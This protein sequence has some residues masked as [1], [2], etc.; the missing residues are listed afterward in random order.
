MVYPA[1]V[2][3]AT[4]LSARQTTLIWTVVLIG[5][6]MLDGIINI[7]AFRKAQSVS[8]VLSWDMTRFVLLGT[9]VYMA[10]IA[11]FLAAMVAAPNRPGFPFLW[12]LSVVFCSAVVA[13]ARGDISLS[14][15]QWVTGIAIVLGAMAFWTYV[16]EVTQD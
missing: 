10:S 16:S 9:I 4:N 8:A 11:L 5:S 15:G 13:A 1:A 6:G 14:R 2:D 7:W 12:P 3:L